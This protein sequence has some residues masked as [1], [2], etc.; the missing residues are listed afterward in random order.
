[1]VLL[2]KTIFGVIEKDMKKQNLAMKGSV[3]NTQT[4]NITAGAV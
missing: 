1:M 2:Q 4:G 3:K